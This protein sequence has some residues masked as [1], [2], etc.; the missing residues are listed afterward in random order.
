MKI[1]VRL[2]NNL[3]LILGFGLSAS[4]P[5]MGEGPGT[6]IKV[7]TIVID[8]REFFLKPDPT[9]RMFWVSR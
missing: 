6:A 4:A 2:L 5:L 9:W 3:T 8:G 1:P 7:E